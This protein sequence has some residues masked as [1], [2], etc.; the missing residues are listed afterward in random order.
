MED[1]QL[2]ENSLQS[3]IEDLKSMAYIIDNIG[4]K[5][6]LQM[7]NGSLFEEAASC[8]ERMGQENIE[9]REKLKVLNYLED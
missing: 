4:D 1:T 5:A 8:L 9:L 6:V 3:L 2:I 7:L